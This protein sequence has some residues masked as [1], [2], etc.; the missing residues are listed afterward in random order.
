MDQLALGKLIMRVN[1][2][3]AL[4]HTAAR[5]IMLTSDPKSTTHEISSAICRDQVIASKVLKLVNSAYYGLPRKIAGVTEAITILGIET[6]R[7][8]VVGA[9]VYH[10]LSDLRSKRMLSPQ[11]IWRHAA[12]CAQSC[13][14]LAAEY[15]VDQ[16]EHVFVTGLLHDIGKII[17]NHFWSDGYSTVIETAEIKGCSIIKAEMEL[18]NSTHAEVGMIIAEKWN[19]PLILVETIGYHHDPLHNCDN[20]DLI[21]LVH[22]GDIMAA[23]AGYSASGKVVYDLDPDVLKKWD[24]TELQLKKLS[25]KTKEDISF[26]FL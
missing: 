20:S 24:L 10:T 8:L 4:P 17:L 13:K 26:E 22:L 3:P 25:V 16:T 14:I 15:G 2:L 7:T 5:V 6:I 1:E 11:K 12:A 19:L 21:Q 18:L 23:M 9:S